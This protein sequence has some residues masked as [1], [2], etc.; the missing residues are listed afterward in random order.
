MRIQAQSLFSFKKTNH[1]SLFKKFSNKNALV[2]NS[3]EIGRDLADKGY[4]F[5]AELNDHKN[6]EKYYRKAIQIFY[7]NEHK[8]DMAGALINLAEV[9]AASRKIEEA[10]PMVIEA[11]KILNNFDGG[12]TFNLTYLGAAKSNLALYLCTQGKQEEAKL[13][14]QEAL[15]IFVK[16]L[17]KHADLTKSTFTLMYQILKK[18]GH[19]EEIGDLEA[20]W[21]TVDKNELTSMKGFTNTDIQ[22]LTQDAKENLVLRKI[23]KPTKEDVENEMTKG[24]KNVEIEEDEE[25]TSKKD[26]NN[27]KEYDDFFGKYKEKQRMIFDEKFGEVLDKEVALAKELEQSNPELDDEDDIYEKFTSREIITEELQQIDSWKIFKNYGKEEA[28]L[29]EK[30]KR[31]QAEAAS[32]TKEEKLPFLE[33]LKKER[34]K[35][36]KKKEGIE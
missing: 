28:I 2:N 19:E 31:L 7:D 22:R 21:K 32:E 11:I 18:L 4:H 5:Q 12:V 14:C 6:A 17:G 16:H 15:M 27:D 1:I 25:T 3:L 8:E 23:K 30:R 34:K 26:N 29:E 9:L 33:K 13:P 20:D 36:A 24:S 35:M 10:I